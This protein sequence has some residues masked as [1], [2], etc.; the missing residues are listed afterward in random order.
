MQGDGQLGQD[1]IVTQ[2]DVNVYEVGQ[3]G[4]GAED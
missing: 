1:L 4:Y 2:A 3:S